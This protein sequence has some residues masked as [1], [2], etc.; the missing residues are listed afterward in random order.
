MAM[1]EK[2]LYSVKPIPSADKY[3]NEIVNKKS[4]FFLLLKIETK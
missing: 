2:G 4:F 3:E 1:I